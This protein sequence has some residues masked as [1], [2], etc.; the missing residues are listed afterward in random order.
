M[1][2]DKT[3]PS[4]LTDALPN[5]CKDS[6]SISSLRRGRFRSLHGPD[7][8][9]RCADWQFLSLYPVTFADQRDHAGHSQRDRL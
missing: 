2:Q 9:A 6:A 1:C 4:R 8:G 3:F 7:F 5:G